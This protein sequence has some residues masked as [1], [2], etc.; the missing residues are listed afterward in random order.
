MDDVAREA[1]VS[2][3]LV[4]LV[5]RA[6]PRVGDA[7]RRAVLRAVDELGYRPN[8]LARNLASRCTH[9]IGVMVNDLHNPFF[10]EM[11]DGMEAFASDHG[12]RLLLN[13]G[14]RRPSS[15]RAAVETLLEFRTDGI[16]LASP[17]LETKAIVRAAESVPVVVLGRALRS[18]HVD[19][20]NSDEE[21]GACLVVDHLHRLG[22]VD[23][24]HFDGG[25][26][27]GA[28]ARRTGYVRAM[29]AIGA[30]GHIRV[31]E[32]DFTEVSGALA[33]NQILEWPDRPTAVF[34]AN[35][36][37]AAGALDRMEECGLRIPD[38]I[39]IVGY[40]NTALA[41]MQH[42]SLSTINQPRKKMGLLAIEVLLERIE[43]HRTQVRRLVLPPQLVARGSSAPPPTRS[44]GST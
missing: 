28:S 5:M 36:L 9:T 18:P 16:V 32:G 40:D 1:G 21:A 6:S 7:R 20:V 4:S 11:L 19:T 23:I 13:S 42:L 25:A 41:A 3:A 26:G 35:D 10:A 43:D 14:W 29:R 17:R 27:A 15:E 12:Y 38:D 24:T 22:H 39:S 2:R 37:M 44:Q 33:A 34:A 30:E 8:V 31:V